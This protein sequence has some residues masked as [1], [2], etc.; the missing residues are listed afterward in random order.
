[1]IW[2]LCIAEGIKMK[3][4]CWWLTVIQA[5]GLT[6]MTALE[7]YLYFRQGPDGVYAGFAVMYMFLSFVMLLG[8]TILASIVS[9]TEHDTHM[10]KHL[11]SLPVPR[12]FVY[13]SKAVWLIVL[14]ALTALF[15]VIGMTFIWLLYTSEPI[16]WDM[17]IKQPFYAFMAAMPA[18]ALQLWLSTRFANQALPIAIGVIG[19]IASLFLARADALWIKA[20]PWA[21]PA[22]SSPFIPNH[23]NWITAGLSVGTLFLAIGS[24]HFA[25][26]EVV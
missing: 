12:S 3:R 2:R 5:V 17:M 9:G 16:P 8:A 26:R 20:L 22:L 15:T 25:R 24:V 7:W 19:A 11:L 23:L 6:L 21:Y 1:M 4:I 14:Q 13:L 10:W 18:L